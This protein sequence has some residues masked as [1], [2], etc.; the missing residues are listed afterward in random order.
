MALGEPADLYQ[1]R[2]QPPC[3]SNVK[4]TVKL[5]QKIGGPSQAQASFEAAPE[6]SMDTAFKENRES[7]GPIPAEVAALIPA[8]FVAWHGRAMLYEPTGTHM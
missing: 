5:V 6:R 1:E 8:K 4:K 2:P 3:P 7:V